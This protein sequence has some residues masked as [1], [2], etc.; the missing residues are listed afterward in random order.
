M[1]QPHQH[2]RHAGLPC[3][4][5][6]LT[7][8]AH[9]LDFSKVCRVPHHR[10]PCRPLLIRAAQLPGNQLHTGSSWHAGDGRPAWFRACTVWAHACFGAAVLPLCGT[11]RARG[12]GGGY[13]VAGH[14]PATHLAGFRPG[15]RYVQYLWLCIDHHA[16]QRHLLAV[17]G[18]QP[19]RTGVC[20]REEGRRTPARTQTSPGLTVRS[21]SAADSTASQCSFW[22]QPCQRQRGI[23]CE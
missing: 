16:L 19:R 4:G 22:G 1:H 14:A 21:R 11:G 5:S 6:A 15:S 23:A 10:L 12:G 13:W 20:R 9:L 18:A 8:A 3:L 7:H 2:L 17:A